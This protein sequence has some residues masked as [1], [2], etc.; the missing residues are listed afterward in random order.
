M[1][2]KKPRPLH[3][4]CLSDSTSLGCRV[5]FIAYALWKDFSEGRITIRAMGLVYIT[6]LSLVPL[7]ALSFSVLKSFGVHNQIQP[8][9]LQMLERGEEQKT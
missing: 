6:L 1:S 7:L 4:I 3:K 8:L 9:L 2:Q 5:Y